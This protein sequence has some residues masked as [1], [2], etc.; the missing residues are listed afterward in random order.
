MKNTVYLL[1]SLFILASVYAQNA[2]SPSWTIQTSTIPSF[3]DF[4]PSDKFLVLESETGYE[5]WDTAKK[6]LYS[7]Q[8]MGR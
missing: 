1:C 6:S 3:I 4:S 7:M 5:V 2:S 8:F